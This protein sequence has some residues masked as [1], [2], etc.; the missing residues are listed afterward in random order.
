LV[1][2]AFCRPVYA[3]IPS[4]AKLKPLAGQVYVYESSDYVAT[5]YVVYVGLRSVTVAGATWTPSTAQKL[6]EA[7]KAVTQLPISEVLDTSPD[8]EWSGGNSYWEGI[9]AKVIAVSETTS[10]LKSE[11]K[12]TA[13]FVAQHSSEFGIR[14]VMLPNETIGDDTQIQNGAVRIL[15]LGA[16]HTPGDVFVYFPN[17]KVLDAG[18]IIKEQVG[19]LASADLVEYP[20]TLEKLKAAKLDIRTVVSGHWSAIHGPEIIDQYE[21]LLTTA[22]R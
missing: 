11:W 7:I 16:S 5:N 2:F 9:G 4:N 15:Y 22:K 18:S 13:D 10:L 8:P 21:K 3:E 6:H 12:P 1:G 14:G 17:E 19:N 20:K